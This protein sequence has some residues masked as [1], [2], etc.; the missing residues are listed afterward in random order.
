MWLSN[1]VASYPAVF[2]TAF[3]L[4]ACL[5]GGDFGGS[6]VAPATPEILRGTGVSLGYMLFDLSLLVLDREKQIKAWGRRDWTLY[7]WHHALSVLVWPYGV[8]K[9][10]GVKFIGT[11]SQCHLYVSNVYAKVC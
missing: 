2:V 9:G 7:L 4:P 1:L 6:W 8:A 11:R 3:A 5:S 10:V